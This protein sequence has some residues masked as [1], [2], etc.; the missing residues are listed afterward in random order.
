MCIRDRA[1]E[2]RFGAILHALDYGAPPHGGI[3]M[4]IDRF[5]MLATDE[6]N[7]REVIAFPKNQRG[8]DLLF[9][10][11]SPVDEEQL[12]DIGL[13]LRPIPDASEHEQAD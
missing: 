3:A 10:A 12:I 5:V 6:K 9:E 4:G 8:S 2:D 11:P 13:A 7:I 1:Q